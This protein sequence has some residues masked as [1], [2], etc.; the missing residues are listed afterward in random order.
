MV[1]SLSSLLCGSTRP[2]GNAASPLFPPLL[3]GGVKRNFANAQHTLELSRE[4][5]ANDANGS[6]LLDDD[7]DDDDDGDDVSCVIASFA[8]AILLVVVVV[9]RDDDDKED[10]DKDDCL[11][12]LLLCPLLATIPPPLATIISLRM[13]SASST[14]SSS[15]SSSINATLLLLL[16]Y[17]NNISRP[18]LTDKSGLTPHTFSDMA[19]N[20][21]ANRGSDNVRARLRSVL[22]SSSSVLLFVVFDDVAAV[23][24]VVVVV[25]AS[26]DGFVGKE[27][28]LA[29][30]CNMVEKLTEFIFPAPAKCVAADDDGDD[31]ATDEVDDVAVVVAVVVVRCT[32][33]ASRLAASL[34]VVNCALNAR[35][36]SL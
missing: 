14:A 18:S 15:S 2:T 26:D 30:L 20:N 19:H 5:N 31:A 11:P 34:H 28:N 10:D 32:N 29:N 27:T 21:K 8:S 35:V 6:L 7:D 9:V 24:V 16:L 17:C 1:S 23:V 13:L 12:F 36:P 4:V 25:V 3:P 33:A 22:S